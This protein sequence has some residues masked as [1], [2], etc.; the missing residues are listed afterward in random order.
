MFLGTELTAVDVE[1][2]KKEIAIQADDYEIESSRRS[3]K[4]PTRLRYTPAKFRYA[5]IQ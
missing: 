3:G 5:N 1:T 4:V 2:V